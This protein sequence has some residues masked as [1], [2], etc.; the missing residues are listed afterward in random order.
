M[1]RFTYA[2]WLPPSSTQKRSWYMRGRGHDVIVNAAMRRYAALC[3]PMRRYAA[4]CGAMRPY[5]ALCG[6]M[7]PYA[8]RWKFM[9]P[10]CLQCD[11]HDHD[12]DFHGCTSEG[13]SGCASEWKSGCASEW[14]SDVGPLL[15]LSLIYN[16]PIFKSARAQTVRL[17]HCCTIYKMLHCCINVVIAKCG[18]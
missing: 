16:S 7:R 4:L 9:P 8:A 10:Y 11:P 17:P 1:C 14:S 5:A 18:P 12:D 3:G 2:T 13:K 6:P 15:Y